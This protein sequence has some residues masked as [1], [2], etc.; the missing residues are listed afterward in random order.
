MS[1]DEVIDEDYEMELGDDQDAFVDSDDDVAPA[2]AP[3]KPLKGRKRFLADLETMRQ[4]CAIG[5]NWHGYDLKST[6]HI[7][8][9]NYFNIVESR[10]DTV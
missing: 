1:D 3:V 9:V 6:C 7:H 8:G 2:P 4:R 10:P 5:F